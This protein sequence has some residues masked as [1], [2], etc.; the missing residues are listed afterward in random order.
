MI[1]KKTHC[2]QANYTV[3]NFYKKLTI[4]VY[5]KNISKKK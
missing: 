3:K 5:K 4:F 2:P 1:Q